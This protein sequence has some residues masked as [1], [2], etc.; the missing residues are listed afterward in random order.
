[1][2]FQHGFPYV[3][4]IEA[5]ATK[6]KLQVGTGYLMGS[7]WVRLLATGFG[8]GYSPVAPGT[9]GSLA[10]L[11]LYLGLGRYSFAANLV[12]VVVLFAA[13]VYICGAAE[14]AFKR[15]DPGEIVLDEIHGMVLALSLLP[16]AAYWPAA[17]VLFRALDVLKPFPAGMLERTL[18]GGWGIMLDD[19]VAA[20]Y[21]VL[22][23]AAYH[24]WF[25]S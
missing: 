25:H 1:M 17:F 14:K 5:H 2:L 18:K 7:R 10:G 3:F 9:V 13:G 8:C 23:L 20:I 12:F 11:L 22:V 16:S 4:P 6:R 21:T 19:V 15:T 24:G